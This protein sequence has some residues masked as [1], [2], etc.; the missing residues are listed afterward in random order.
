[1]ISSSNALSVLALSAGLSAA[2]IS[3]TGADGPPSTQFEK[4]A[5]NI[6][7]T[8]KEN[9]HPHID[10]KFAH[11]FAPGRQKENNNKKNHR[12][13][14]QQHSNNNGNANTQF[15][16]IKKRFVEEDPSVTSVAADVGVLP[17][18]RRRNQ[19]NTEAENGLVGSDS[20]GSS[21]TSSSSRF[22]EA[23]ITCGAGIDY[24]E[25]IDGKTADDISCEEA[26][27]GECCVGQDACS[28]FTGRICRDGS[29][30]GYRAC[31]NSDIGRVVNSCHGRR[32]CEIA[33]IDTVIDS[34]V[35]YM[36]CQYSIMGYVKNSCLNETCA[37]GEVCDVS[38]FYTVL[39][40]V[41]DSC[42]GY[43]AC[44]LMGGGIAYVG[45]VRNSC[46]GELSCSAAFILGATAGN[47]YDSCHGEWACTT[48][49]SHGGTV[50]NMYN[51]C[52]DTESWGHTCVGAA[53][54]IGSIGDMTNACIGLET[55]P[56][57][58]ARDGNVGNVAD[59]CHGHLACEKFGESG[60]QLCVGDIVYSCNADE[61]CLNAFQEVHT[62]GPLTDCCNEENV[63]EGVTEQLAECA[64][65]SETLTC[66]Y[67]PCVLVGNNHVPEEAFPL[68]RCEG[69]CDSDKDCQGELVCFSRGGDTANNATVFGCTGE[70]D[71]GDDFCV[72]R[73]SETYLAYVG[74]DGYPEYKF[75]LGLC[76]GHCRKHG[77]CGDGLK[78]FRRRYFDP[79]PGCDGAGTRGK[80]YCIPEDLW[81][82]VVG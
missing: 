18:R 32:V 4:M 56:M 42:H 59:S 79:V 78:C 11:K 66:D 81:N 69:D 52:I 46:R 14:E 37:E 77:N 26:C 19:K 34:C 27:A 16:G 82:S 23:P 61:S 2:G 73:P 67:R 76:E 29:C 80:N 50:G 30:T 28:D 74:M 9:H 75:P 71:S 3:A 15:R 60:G 65:V 48:M 35:D 8:L 38:C 33:A 55:C 31:A 47:I 57:M 24:V 17:P 13:L 6:I 43:Q 51:S 49:S 64:A 25:C 40:S 72:V 10:A 45:N 63:C 5:Q 68:D 36:A 12:H 1:M 21:T 53:M 70:D 22:L 7:H 44:I 58:G 20:E 62:T 39:D 41:V 54:Y